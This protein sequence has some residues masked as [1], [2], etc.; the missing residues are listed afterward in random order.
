MAKGKKS[1]LAVAKEDRRVA[2]GMQELSANRSKVKDYSKVNNIPFAKTTVPKFVTAVQ[3]MT[4]DTE[5]IIPLGIA[6]DISNSKGEI[7]KISSVIPTTNEE[8]SYDSG[9]ANPIKRKFKSLIDF[10]KS[11][12]DGVDVLGL[13][14]K[15]NLNLKKKSVGFT[16]MKE[17]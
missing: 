13:T 5:E 9:D 3:D 2:L 4:I 17:F 1:S 12:S 11:V 6:P 8:S 10:G 7:K 16:L 15:P 14:V